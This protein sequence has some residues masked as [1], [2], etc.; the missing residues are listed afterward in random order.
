MALLK[1]IGDRL[2]NLR[3]LNEQN[4]D[5]K[6]KNQ[7]GYRNNGNNNNIGGSQ[8][9]KQRGQQQI[10]SDRKNLAVEVKGDKK[11]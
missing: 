5:P 2:E 9:G 8:K 1:D 11:I 4:N 6:P 10:S 7:N 3:V